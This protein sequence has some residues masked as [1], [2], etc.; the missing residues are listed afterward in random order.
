MTLHDDII[1]QFGRSM[2][3]QGLCLRNDGALRLDM[4]QLGSLAFELVGPYREDVSVS[5]TRQVEMVD[6]NA[7]ERILELCHYRSPAPFPARAGLAKAGHLIFAVRL[8]TSEFTLP[9]LHQTLEL[10]TSLHDR[11]ASFVRPARLA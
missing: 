11:S 2:G 10:L 5:L 6:D 1:D 3:M 9:G 4:Q 7:A 8:E